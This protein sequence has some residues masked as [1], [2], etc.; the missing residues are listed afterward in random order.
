MKHLCLVIFGLL[1]TCL[2]WSQ[3]R[4]EFLSEMNNAIE[5]K[6][7]VM[8]LL[9]KTGIVEHR[10]MG[11]IYRFKLEDIASIKEKVVEQNFIIN[12]Y[13]KDDNCF[14]IYR[15]DSVGTQV[16]NNAYFFSSAERAFLFAKNLALLS[17]SY[18]TNG[19]KVILEVVNEQASGNK[20]E[21]SAV[22]PKDGLDDYLDS[23]TDKEETN[24]SKKQHPNLT[25]KED[26]DEDAD[27]DRS[28]SKAQE[29]KERMEDIKANREEKK[30]QRK[31]EFEEKREQLK[32]EQEEQRE[33]QRE[34]LAAKKEQS[35]NAK[36]TRRTT[37]KEEDDKEAVSGL[38]SED[39][40]ENNAKDKR[41]DAL[42]K[43]LDMILKSAISSDFKSIEGAETNT[44]K[45][46]NESKVRWKGARKSYVT[47]YK[48]KRAFIAE[49]KSSKDFE[50]LQIE[51][52]ELQTE[53]EK[54]LGDDWDFTDKSN[55]EEYAD[56]NGEI[57]DTE[58]HNGATNGPK[59]RIILISDNDKYTLF[60]RIQ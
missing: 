11:G 56:F 48:G 29:A 10:E 24:P 38:A 36:N 51:Y 55:D 2:L 9:E 46:I 52:D 17:N 1:T 60:V 18:K 22:K 6:K 21:T 14:T 40:N 47:N 57:R 8:K 49:I 43:P 50:L 26:D 42:C 13:C 31:D 34:E 54:C 58:Y 12:V 32:A 7:E 20:T 45:H 28:S 30:Q 4:T 39:E 25:K 23:Q 16:N 19:E 41:N 35:G 53:L 59:L 44:L 5:N 37:Q 15:N 27:V 33:K 3:Q